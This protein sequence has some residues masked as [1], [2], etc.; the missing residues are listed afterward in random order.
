M[1]KEL[2]IYISGTNICFRISFDSEYN[3][4]FRA[5]EYKIIR[6]TNLKTALVLIRIICLYK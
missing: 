1:L 6:T 5:S 2:E 3:T 4:N